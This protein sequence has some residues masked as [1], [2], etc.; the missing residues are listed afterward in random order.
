MRSYRRIQFVAA[1][2]I[3]NGALALWFMPTPALAG[4]CAP[5]VT[6]V[7]NNLCPSAQSLCQQVAPPGC[8]LKG[9]LCLANYCGDPNY[10]KLECF[11]Q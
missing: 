8:T 5:Y 2:V 1:A 4:S 7:E 10:S 6:C 11:Y 3:A 9:Y